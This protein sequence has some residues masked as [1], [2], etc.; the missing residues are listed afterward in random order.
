MDWDDLRFFLA[1]A[2][3][4]SVRGAGD[5]LT[6]SHSTVVR[7]IEGLEKRL[8]TRLFDR[9]RDGYALTEAGQRILPGAER[10]ERELAA[11][12]RGTVG[13]DER[14]EGPV[15]ITCCDT[16]VSN[17][18]ICG[19]APFCREHPAIEL[20]VVA[21]G[22]L[23]DLARRE[24]DL[25]IRALPTTSEPNGDLLG[26]RLAPL[27]LANYVAREHAA[28][29][30]P[31]LVGTATRWTSFDDRSIQDT[32]IARSSFPDVPAWGGFTSL[33]LMAQACRA[34]QGI[35]MLPTYVGDRD[36]TLRRLDPPDLQHLA[37]IWL[38]SHPDLRDNARFR[39]VRAA[40]RAIFSRLHPF[41]LGEQPR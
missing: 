14:L 4:G 23:F 25:A 10:M 37:D 26:T 13:R 8:S 21:D 11:I 9:S 36:P 17:D 12:E 33:E 15:T 3:A 19:L 6:V 40:V 5:R 29:L 41:F 34:G 39:A 28:Q 7:R 2:R 24:A 32:L 38:V 16:W 30:D 22:R 20:H 31:N 27:I 35:T 18:V 1:L